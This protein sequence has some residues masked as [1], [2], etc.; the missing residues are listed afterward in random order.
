MADKQEFGR[1]STRAHS[2]PSDV[3]V[4]DISW[5]QSCFV[6]QLGAHCL[7][8][9]GQS[10]V[11]KVLWIVSVELSRDAGTPKMW[12]NGYLFSDGPV[13][14]LSLTVDYRDRK[15]KTRVCT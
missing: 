3:Q 11:V 2:P 8:N 5:R 10:V 13:D 6:H 4:F 9:T 12:M 14:M 7:K 1:A 15:T